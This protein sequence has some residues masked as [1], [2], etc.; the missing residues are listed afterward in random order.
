MTSGLGLGSRIDPLDWPF[1]GVPLPASS[2]LSEKPFL[3]TRQTTCSY[4][5]GLAC[6]P[7]LIRHTPQLLTSCPTIFFSP[8]QVQLPLLIQPHQQRVLH[9]GL[10][11]PLR[12]SLTS[13]AP[14]NVWSVRLHHTGL[15][16][17]LRSFLTSQ[18]P[19]N[20]WSVCLHH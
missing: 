8:L 1:T 3:P 19:F 14:F 20:V 4:L 18:A 16:L 17:H 13:Q 5:F 11:L 12:S 2:F 10:Q 15:Q 9:T 6:P 7:P